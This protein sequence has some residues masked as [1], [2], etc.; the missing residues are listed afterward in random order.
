MD[1]VAVGLD[2]WS[3]AVVAD[4]GNRFGGWPDIL[5]I[6]RAMNFGVPGMT[7]EAV[8]KDAGGILTGLC[9]ADADIA[10]VSLLGN[11]ALNA[12]KNDGQ[13]TADE[14]IAGIENMQI[15]MTRIT[16][17]FR[18]T[19]VILYTT[20]D[21]KKRVLAMMLNKCLEWTCRNYPGVEFVPSHEA[22]EPS[23]HFIES[24]PIHITEAGHEVLADQIK[25]IIEQ[26]MM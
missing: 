18:R 2:S 10:V 12:F 16:A 26:P 22:L 24:D 13:I 21:H 7:A 8:A 20:R 6:P 15:A 17:C 9:G 1:N 3:S 11:D 4:T 23:A 19:L 5:G 14:M 25:R